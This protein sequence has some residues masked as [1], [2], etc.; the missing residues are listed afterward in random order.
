[1]GLLLANVATVTAEEKKIYKYTDENGVTH[2]TETKPN[3]DY[4]EADL[5]K[6]SIIESTPSTPST[7]TAGTP[8]SSA[9]ATDPSEVAAFEILEP[10]NEQNL[11]GTGGKLKVTVPALNEQQQL[12]YK[13][14]IVLD[15]KK[16]KPAD[17]STQEF[18]GIYRGEHTVQALLVDRLSNKVEKRSKTI[19]FF[20]HQNSKK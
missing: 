15:G 2:Y 4:K 3:D 10:V 16:R 12:R 20:M 5:P 14:Q 1:M 11:W 17:G 8:G 13:V 19:T 6:L 18:T 7:S 9:E